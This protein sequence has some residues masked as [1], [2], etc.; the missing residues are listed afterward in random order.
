MLLLTSIESIMRIENSSYNTSEED[1]MM[2][3]EHKHQCN[4]ESY[5]GERKGMHAPIKYVSIMRS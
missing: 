2:L 1:C 4:A 3:K 5:R